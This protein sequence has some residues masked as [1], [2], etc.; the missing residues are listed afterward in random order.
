MIVYSAT[1]Q[2]FT[3]D[4]FSNEIEKRIL[5]SFRS[6]HGISMGENE[7]TAWRNSMQY[8]NNLL[9]DGEIP[10]DAGVAIEHTIPQTAKRIDFILLGQRVDYHGHG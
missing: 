7:V 5:D 4:V 1:R 6:R 10:A 9:L 2:E 8:M 3:D